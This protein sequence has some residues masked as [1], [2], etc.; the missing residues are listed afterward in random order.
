MGCLVLERWAV[1]QHQRGSKVPAPLVG[2]RKMMVLVAE[3]AVIGVAFAR[4]RGEL[5]VHAERTG[6]AAIGGWAVGDCCG[7]AVILA[8]AAAAAVVFGTG[9]AV[10]AA[11]IGGGTQTSG[12][13]LEVQPRVW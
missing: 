10:A 8:A 6:V 12:R 13:R 2:D 4:G 3:E 9:V 1:F 11:E 7:K 5:E